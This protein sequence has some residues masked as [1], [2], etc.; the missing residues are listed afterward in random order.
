MN[1]VEYKCASCGHDAKK[2]D[3]SGRCMYEYDHGQELECECE[4]LI[5]PHVKID[6]EYIAHQRK[7][8]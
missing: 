5:A 6:E 4:K 3:A 7:M 8:F 1:A 2:H